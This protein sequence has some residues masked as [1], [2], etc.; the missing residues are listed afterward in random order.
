MIGIG[1]EAEEEEASDGETDKDK[2]QKT[3]KAV[4]EKR[5]HGE[6]VR[7]SPRAKGV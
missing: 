1:A 3:K 4:G 7:R 5:S 2:T 6:A